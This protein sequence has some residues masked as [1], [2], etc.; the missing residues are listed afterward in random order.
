MPALFS[1]TDLGFPELQGWTLTQLKALHK[2]T[3]EELARRGSGGR[4]TAMQAV[5]NCWNTTMKDCKNLAQIRVLSGVRKRHLTARLNEPAFADN[6][7]MIFDCISHSKWHRGEVSS[8]HASFD[9]IIAND[10]N[11]AKAL[12]GRFK[13]DVL[14]AKPAPLAR[15]G[16]DLWRL[17]EAKKPTP[18]S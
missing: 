9:W 6:F 7:P 5:V 3:T 4:E 13:R 2:A 1:T 10:Q 11:Y 12:E 8:W 15:P 16:D 17:L 14:D 18:A